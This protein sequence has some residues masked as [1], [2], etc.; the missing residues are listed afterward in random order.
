MAAPHVTGVVALMMQAAGGTLTVDE[1]RDALRT[2]ARTAPQ[3]QSG[4]HPRYG[5][6]RI[7]AVAAVRANAEPVD[8]VVVERDT[9]MAAPP[10]AAVPSHHPLL[11]HLVSSLVNDAKSRR[12]RIRFEVEVEPST[13]PGLR[14]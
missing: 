9:A 13:Q 7:D 5:H 10:A 14:S 3:T 2:S 4:W 8:A 6:G 12:V 11:E 1:I